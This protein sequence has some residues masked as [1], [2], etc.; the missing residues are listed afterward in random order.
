MTACQ[1]VALLKQILK[2]TQHFLSV[3]ICLAEGWWLHG[4]LIG[5]LKCNAH[6]T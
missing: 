3:F 5:D 1:R 4:P 2:K 6:V